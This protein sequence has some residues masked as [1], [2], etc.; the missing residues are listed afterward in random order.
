[1]APDQCRIT[2]QV[3]IVTG[4]GAGIGRAIALALAE[5]GADIVI[6][7]IIPER[8]A[9]VAARIAEHGRACLAIPTDMA[10]PDQVAAMV[11]AAQARFGRIDILVN[12]VGGV[13]RKSFLDQS[14]NSWR[15]HIDLN[16]V[17]M[18]AATSAAVPH[19]IAGSLEDAAFALGYVHAQD[20][21]WQMELMRRLGQGRLAG[22]TTLF[23]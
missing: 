16:L 5:A 11:D 3:A 6:A 18:L 7:D 15:R 19:I 10:Q 17:S 4:G 14:Q 21:F 23:D 12:N 20:R 1:M 9:E 22:D 2:D 13:G 8:G